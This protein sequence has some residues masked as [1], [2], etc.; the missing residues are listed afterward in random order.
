MDEKG[1][2]LMELL[3]AVALLGIVFALISSV[4]QLSIKSFYFGE[5]R[6][7]VHQEMILATRF[8]TDEVRNVT[9]DKLQIV[10]GSLMTPIGYETLRVNLDSALEHRNP[11]HIATVLTA[12]VI[13]TV[14]FTIVPV[15]DGFMLHYRMVARDDYVVESQI[16]L[17]NVVDVPLEHRG[18]GSILQFRRPE[19]E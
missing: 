5:Q 10:D 2:T 17:R 15:G 9:E 8:L 19:R 6:A 3:V 12:P 1:F 13:E 14:T 18:P 7:V 16:A 4:Y 11:K